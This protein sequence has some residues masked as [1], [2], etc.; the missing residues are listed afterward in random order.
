MNAKRREY[1]RVRE[2]RHYGLDGP[3]SQSKGAI[4]IMATWDDHD[5]G[6]N[7]AGTK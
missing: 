3:I 6:Y 4:P 5:Y 7:N 1:N 2:E